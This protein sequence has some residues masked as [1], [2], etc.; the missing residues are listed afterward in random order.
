[1]PHSHRQ[2][3]TLNYAVVKRNMFKGRRKRPCVYCWTFL[4]CDEATLDH[5]VSLARGGYDKSSNLVIACRA[6]NEAKGSLSRDQFLNKLKAQ[7][8]PHD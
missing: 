1:M 2:R 4:T 7:R 8:N 6:C 5:V 3:R